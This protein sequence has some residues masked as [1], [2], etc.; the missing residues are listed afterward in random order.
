MINEQSPKIPQ[1]FNIIN[2]LSVYKHYA[3]QTIVFSDTILVY[4]KE[5]D[6]PTHYYL[7]Y[8][9][10]F[11][12]QLF[13]RLLSIDV[14]YRGL[15]T[16]GEFEFKQLENI[17]A[18]WG[19]ALLDSYEDEDKLLGFGLFVSKDVSEDILIFDKMDMGG[20]YDFI[21]LCQSYINLYK[22]A[23]GILPVELEIITE[24]DD[25]DRIDED[26]MFLRQI[27]EMKEICPCEKIRN[28]Y[29]AVYNW[30]KERTPKFFKLFEEKG[31]MPFVIN[32]NYIGSINPWKMELT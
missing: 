16:Y 17:Q 24:T 29:V 15:I 6:K 12:Q 5:N 18:Y 31:F 2:E 3:F 19:K 26:L 13:Y 8:M 20:K 22:R 11:A 9:V 25:F 7:T 1:I 4:N 32:S 21:F 30:Y 14:Y 28:K 10:E 27:A 23:K